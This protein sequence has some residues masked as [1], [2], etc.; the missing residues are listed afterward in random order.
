MPTCAQCGTWNQDASK[1]CDKCGAKLT[2]EVAAAGPVAV[3]TPAPQPAQSA[4]SA[5]K[6]GFSEWR[7]RNFFELAALLVIAMVAGV[8]LGKSA[9]GKYDSSGKCTLDSNYTVETKTR[10]GSVESVKYLVTYKFDVNGVG[11]TGK[12]GLNSEP[13]DPDATVYYM[14]GNPRENA[15]G[16]ARTL[17]FNMGA[18]GVAFLIALIAYGLI[19]K[20]SRWVA[21]ADPQGFGDSCNEA[22]RMKHGKYSAWVHVHAAFFLQAGLIALLV[23]LGLAAVSHMDA[24]SYSIL[25]IATFVAVATTLCVYADRWSCIEAFSSRSCSGVA[26]LS[27]FYVPVIAFVYANY[28]GLKKLRGR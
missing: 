2:P 21:G 12:D 11:Y 26:N 16:P 17:K 25:G 14:A 24:T 22:A 28:R 4:A 15:L 18:S 9:I 23:A 10:N 1:T 19:P 3:A 8:L 13:T 5:P 20:T 7:Q 6:S 27:F